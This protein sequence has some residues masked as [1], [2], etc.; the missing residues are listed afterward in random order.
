MY[1]RGHHCDFNF[2]YCNSDLETLN[3]V[4]RSFSLVIFFNYFFS[5][6]VPFLIEPV[7]VVLSFAYFTLYATNM[8]NFLFL[9]YLFLFFVNNSNNLFY[10][11]E[12]SQKSHLEWFKFFI[13]SSIPTKY[14]KFS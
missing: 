9:K 1:I 6:H 14:F 12:A 11:K 8:R 13:C 7:T 5:F 10:F 2:R 4:L 3:Q